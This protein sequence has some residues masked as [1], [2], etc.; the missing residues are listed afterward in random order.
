MQ[1]AHYHI[2]DTITGIAKKTVTFAMLLDWFTVFAL[3]YWAVVIGGFYMGILV[4]TES[5]RHPHLRLDATDHPPIG[6]PIRYHRSN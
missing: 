6:S 1:T 5:L 3:A 2:S 4:H